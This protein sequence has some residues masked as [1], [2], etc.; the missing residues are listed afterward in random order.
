MIVACRDKRSREHWDSEVP[1]IGGR[2]RDGLSPIP[3]Y[4][5]TQRRSTRHLRDDSLRHCEYAMT[6]SSKAPNG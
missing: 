5:R 6:G 3:F 1:A 4:R 2:A